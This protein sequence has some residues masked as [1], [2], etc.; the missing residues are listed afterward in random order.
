MLSVNDPSAKISKLWTVAR[1]LF[2]LSVVYAVLADLPLSLANILSSNAPTHHFSV[3]GLLADASVPW[4]K[5]G[6]DMLFLGA[7]L[8][9]VVL[10]VRQGWQF[11][12]SIFVPI[13]LPYASLLVLIAF[14]A[15]VVFF[16]DGFWMA[17]IGARA[18]FALLAFLVGLHLS[19]KDMKMI[20]VGIF[21]LILY[22]AIL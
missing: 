2:L 6:K 19:H 1:T 10:I 4:G 21:F 15:A 3:P 22:R 18:H 20:W 11:P 12:A 9:I 17:I 5:I 14:L 7:V 13:I 16:Q 8:C